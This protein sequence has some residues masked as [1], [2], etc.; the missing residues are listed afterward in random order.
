MKNLFKVHIPLLLVNI[1]YGVNFTIAKSVMPQY[2]Q[3]LAF[4]I[5]RVGVS[6]VLFFLVHRAFIRQR[7]N[8]AD[9][10]K[11]LLC[12]V[13]GVYLNQTLFFEGIKYTTPIHG[14]LIMIA[15]PILVLILS[16]I[17]AKE[18]PSILKTIGIVLGALGAATLILFGKELTSGTNTVLGDSLVLLN[19]ICFALYLVMVKPLMRKYHPLTV[20]LWIFALGFIFVLPTGIYQ[21]TKIEWHTFTFNVWMAV[22]SVVIGATF[23]VYLL[24]NI[25]LKHASASVVGIYIYLQPLVAASV[26]LAFGKE[27]FSSIKIISAIL[28]FTGVALVNTGDKLIKQKK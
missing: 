21:F 8:K 19:A 1:I 25:A 22:A 24:N 28:I 9:L 4:I 7:V 3:P 23:F 20:V 2:V 26:S 17:I 6:T 13:F 12:A 11:L 16:R 14:S 15:T 5:L 18:P 27:H 10:G